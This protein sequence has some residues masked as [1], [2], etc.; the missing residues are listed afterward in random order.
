MTQ[1]DKSLSMEAEFL[2]AYEKTHCAN[3]VESP[4]M[5]NFVSLGNATLFIDKD[6]KKGIYRIRATQGHGIELIQEKR[7][8]YDILITSK[9][10]TDIKI[11]FRILIKKIIENEQLN[12]TW[13]KI[14]CALH[15]SECK[16]NALK[17]IL[18][19][20]AENAETASQKEYQQS[21]F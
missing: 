11:I 4:T 12:K 18:K 8:T 1:R 7:K 19:S 17:N 2:T 9:S 14:Q 6:E 13:D 15:Q 20:N 21:L 16:I 5:Y 3:E 10:L